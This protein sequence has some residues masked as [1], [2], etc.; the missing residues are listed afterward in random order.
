L[1]SIYWVINHACHRKCRHCYDDRFR[2]YVRDALE[3]K[4]RESETAFDKIIENLPDALGYKDEDG[5]QQP[6]R[7]ILAGGEVLVDPVRERILYPILE[8]LNA[9]YGVA[10]NIIVQTAGDLVTDVIL[11][12]L[13][14][15]GIWMVSVAGMDDCLTSATMGH[16]AHSLDRRISGS[17]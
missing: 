5:R 6:G 3:K 16:L 11:D 17:S 12:E 7:I 15:Y 13:L 14:S 4:V 9:K 10:A 2:P 1:E 8:K